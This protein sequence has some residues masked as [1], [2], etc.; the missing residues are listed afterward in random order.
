MGKCVFVSYGHT[1]GDCVLNRLKPCLE[2]GGAKVRVDVERFKTG[3]GLVGQ[4]D[5]EQDAAELDVLV[6]SK[7]YF[8]SDYCVHEFQRA[9]KRDPGFVEGTVV[10]VLR[11]DVDWRENLTAEAPPLLVDLRDDALPRLSRERQ[12]KIVAQWDRL[13]EACGAD[14]GTSTPEWLDARDAQRAAVPAKSYP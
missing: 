7:D 3:R 8:D 13:L 10:P 4:M 12:Q 9:L 5:A 1:Q 11:D 2:A 14:L 6:L